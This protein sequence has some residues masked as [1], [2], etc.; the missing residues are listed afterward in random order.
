MAYL[1][2]KKNTVLITGANRGLG[3]SLAR[4]FANCG[5]HLILHCRHA[6]PE[7]FDDARIIMGD[8]EEQ[9]TIMCLHQ[10]IFNCGGLDVLINNAAIYRKHTLP[11]AGFA[12]IQHVLNTNLYIPI[13]LTRLFWPFLKKRKGLVI[14]INSLAGKEG[15]E[16]ELAYSVSKHGLA[17]FS[18][19][20]QFDGVRDNVRV[21]DVFLGAMATGMVDSRNL[22]KEKLIDPT[23]VAD[24][25]T[26]L[27]STAYASLR[28]PEITLL[29][30]KY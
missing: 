30:S 18:K 24:V 2:S 3:L 14:N 19:T 4:A 22:N 15:G 6:M 7:L 29:R 9:T 1:S 8:L 13:Q 5:Y 10:Y 17:G 20:L 25:V 28:I 16:G 26:T 21:T 11:L 23:E 12:E 27:C